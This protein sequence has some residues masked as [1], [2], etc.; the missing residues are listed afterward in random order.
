MAGF[1]HRVVFEGKDGKEVVAV[2]YEDLSGKKSLSLV[3]E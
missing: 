3:E 2:V 1:N